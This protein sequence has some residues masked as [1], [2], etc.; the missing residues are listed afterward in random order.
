MTHFDSVTEF[1]PAFDLSMT[2]G[3]EV[4]RATNVA[5]ESD[6]GTVHFGCWPCS[7]H[8]GRAGSGQ[9]LEG[10]LG[11]QFTALAAV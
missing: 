6:S 1:A 4:T 3:S 7:R 11:L 9:R 8:L 5:F 10:R 2:S